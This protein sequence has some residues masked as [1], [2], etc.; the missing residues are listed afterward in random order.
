MGVLVLEIGEINSADLITMSSSPNLVTTLLTCLFVCIAVKAGIGCQGE[1]L[2]YYLGIAFWLVKH[3]S[4]TESQE[5]L[6][7]RGFE[8]KEEQVIKPIF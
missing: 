7:E 2:L 3:Q 6:G 4:P 5:P 1:S 8:Q